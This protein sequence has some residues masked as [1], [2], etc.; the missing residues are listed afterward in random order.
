MTESGGISYLKPEEESL[1]D[2]SAA[3]TMAQEYS[4][5]GQ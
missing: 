3:Y 1:E 4:R 5:A 2:Q